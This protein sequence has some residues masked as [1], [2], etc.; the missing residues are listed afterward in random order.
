MGE[1][2]LWCFGSLKKVELINS[3][4]FNGVEDLDLILAHMNLLMI[5]IKIR[6]NS[7]DK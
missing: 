3:E 6:F 7:S 4:L 1:F 5:I 2:L